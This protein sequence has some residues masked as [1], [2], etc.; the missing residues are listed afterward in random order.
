MIVQ[1]DVKRQGF[2]ADMHTHS[3]NSHDSEC[4]IADMAAAEAAKGISAFAVTDHCDI[5]KYPQRNA[6]CIIK[7][8]IAEMKAQNLDN[9]KLLKGVELGDGIWNEELSNYILGLTDYDV[10]IGS[11]HVVK[12][13]ECSQS[14]SRIDF[15]EMPMED[16]Y[17]Y[18]EMYFRDVLKTLQQFPCDIMA[19]LT[20]PLR[21]IRGKYG[22]DVDMSRFEK[23]IDEIL[24]YIIEHKI[25]MEVNTSSLKRYHWTMP[26]EQ[27]IK[28]YREMGGYFITLGS[29]AHMAEHAASGFEQALA[30]LK[31]IGFSEI[32]YYEKH[33]AIPCAI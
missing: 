22:I 29:D 25:A 19:H 16:I 18:L 17:G 8:S 26:D 12:Y 4:P 9:I 14:C 24:A 23:Q 13:K 15:S 32:Y 6:P 33:Q 5:L 28:R 30:M 27:I 2:L 31:R 7:S 1:K 20:F 11:V 21:T 3:R 10:I